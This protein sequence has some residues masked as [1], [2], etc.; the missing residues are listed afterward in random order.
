MYSP[1]LLQLAKRYNTAV[2]NPVVFEALT[3]QKTISFS[4]TKIL[5]DTETCSPDTENLLAY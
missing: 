4:P 1:G 3:E 2:H 5:S